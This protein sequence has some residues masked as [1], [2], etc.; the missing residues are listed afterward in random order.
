MASH[1]GCA[2]R[3][4]ALITHAV[5]NKLQAGGSSLVTGHRVGAGQ[6]RVHALCAIVGFRPFPREC[7]TGGDL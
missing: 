2:V 1:T 6:R 3:G 5:K 7:L 4:F